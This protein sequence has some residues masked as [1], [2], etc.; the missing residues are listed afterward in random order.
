MHHFMRH[1]VTFVTF[2]EGKWG[3]KSSGHPPHSTSSSPRNMAVMLLPPSCLSCAAPWGCCPS[4]LVICPGNLWAWLMLG[5]ALTTAEVEEASGNT[6]KRRFWEDNKIPPFLAKNG[7]WEAIVLSSLVE[8]FWD[9]ML[10]V[11]KSTCYSRCCCKWPQF[12]HFQILLQ[13]GIRPFVNSALL[14][15][16]SVICLIILGCASTYLYPR[17]FFFS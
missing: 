9:G 7:G 15:C 16:S 6:A 8:C 2:K 3:V 17:L 10:N 11:L 12:L 4:C 1:Q 5:K 14:K 13:C